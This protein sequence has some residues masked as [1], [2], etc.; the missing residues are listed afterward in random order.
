MSRT[1]KEKSILI[2]VHEY[3]GYPGRKVHQI[4]TLVDLWTADGIDVRVA[5][6]LRDPIGREHADLVIPHVNLSV[7]PDQYRAWLEE[8]PH[9]VNAGVYDIRKRTISANLVTREDAYDGPVIVKTDLNYG[10]MSEL[11]MAHRRRRASF[12]GRLRGRLGGTPK[13]TVPPVVDLE[14]ATVLPDK[15]YRVFTAKSEVPRGV[16]DNRHLVVERFLPEKRGDAYV[17]RSYG[18]LGD[19]AYCELRGGPNPLGKPR[20]VREF[21]EPHPDIVEMR[22]RMGWDYGKFD[23]VVR[24]GQAILLDANKTPGTAPTP[25]ETLRRSNALAPG[26]HALLAEGVSEAS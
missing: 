6:G 17:A 5:V 26:I 9:V 1:D 8:R 2:L 18:F 25:D 11:A 23:Y 7:V 12:V 14:T 20:T 22:Y 10:G 21:C 15:D 24:D 4:W 19:R 3:D 16:F 13:L